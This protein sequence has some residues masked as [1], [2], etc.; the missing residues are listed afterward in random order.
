MLLKN[1]LISGGCGFIGSHLVDRLLKRRDIGRLVVVDNLW[2][3]LRS[4]LSL[5][6]Q[7]D[8]RLSLEICD[9]E[10]ACPQ[11]VTDRQR[12]RLI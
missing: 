12:P 10:T 1:I 7:N 9:V 3:G 8:E 2:T 4:N 5:A 11:T 6:A